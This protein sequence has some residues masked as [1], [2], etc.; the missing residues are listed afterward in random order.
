[1]N[2][3]SLENARIKV[4]WLTNMKDTRATMKE[5]Y[6]QYNCPHC[7]EGVNEGVLE[8]SQH[9]M[10][11][12]AYREMRHGINLSSL[13]CQ[14]LQLHHKHPAFIYAAILCVSLHFTIL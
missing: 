9:L 14:P 1:M 12:E 4:L 7:S 3:K 5:K 2:D 6:K 10:Q 13:D 11:C 8:S